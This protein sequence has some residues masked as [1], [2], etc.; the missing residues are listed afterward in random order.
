MAGG[1]ATLE[2]VI[3]PAGYYRSAP[4]VWHCSGASGPFRMWLIENADS[5]GILIPKGVT[6]FQIIIQAQEDVDLELTDFTTGKYIVKYDGP[7]VNNQQRSGSYQGINGSLPLVTF[8]GDDDEPPVSENLTISG[9]TGMPVYLHFHNLWTTPGVISAWYSF[10]FLTPCPQGLLGCTTYD[11]IQAESTVKAW[12]RWMQM[13]SSSADEAWMQS[14]KDGGQILYYCWDR[15]WEH[16]TSNPGNSSWQ[17]S[18][19]YIDSNNDGMITQEEFT[20]AYQLYQWT[21]EDVRQSVS[22][23]SCWVQR[24][25]SAQGAWNTYSN[26]AKSITSSAWGSTIWDQWFPGPDDLKVDQASSFRFC[27]SMGDALLSSEEFLKCYWLG[28]GSATVIAGPA[29]NGH[30]FG[31]LALGIALLTAALLTLLIWYCCRKKSPGK[32]YRAL[33]TEDEPE[34]MLEDE[35]RPLVSQPVRFL[36][37]AVHYRAVPV[38]RA[39]KMFFQPRQAVVVTPGS[40]VQGSTSPP[41][42]SVVSPIF[43]TGSPVASPSYRPTTQSLV[44]SPKR[45]VSALSP[46]QLYSASPQS[47]WTSPPPLE[48]L[49]SGYARQMRSNPERASPSLAMTPNKGV[50]RSGLNNPSWESSLR[51]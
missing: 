14:E 18:F 30:S 40:P 34:S 19:R 16:W 23:W 20:T 45:S 31:Y 46:K 8:S 48:D 26:G 50:I 25:H 51:N 24:H 1:T 10:S 12:S 44:A 4:I 15:I 29:S 42:A 43:F 21:P 41:S 22:D 39:V 7:A 17:Y 36:P 3:C 13:Q 27:D 6:D 47:R 2:H 37:P 35:M 49:I 9:T 28:G 33:P 38:Y 32:V 11:G 5:A